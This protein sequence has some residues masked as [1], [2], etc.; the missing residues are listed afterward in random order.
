MFALLMFHSFNLSSSVHPRAFA[1]NGHFISRFLYLSYS[2]VCVSVCIKCPTV[3]LNALSFKTN[4]ECEC[5][6]ASHLFV[7]FVC[8]FVC[9]KRSKPLIHFYGVSLFST[10]S[11]AHRKCKHW[12]AQMCFIFIYLAFYR[13]IYHFSVRT[14]CVNLIPNR[15]YANE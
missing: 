13:W 3:I 12:N 9:S 11:R 15:I 5:A 14:R 2:A 1:F 4:V 6:R 7:L 8:L 10:S